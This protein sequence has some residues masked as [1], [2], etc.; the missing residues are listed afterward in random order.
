MIGCRKFWINK[1]YLTVHCNR[2][3]NNFIY[4]TITFSTKEN[5]RLYYLYDGNIIQQYV[6]NKFTKKRQQ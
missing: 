2:Y 1:A 5:Y 6:L 3:F 4:L